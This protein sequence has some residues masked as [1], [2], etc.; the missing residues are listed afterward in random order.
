MS[1]PPETRNA[2]VEWTLILG[3]GL[4]LAGLLRFSLR[5]FESGD[6]RNFIG[7]WYDFIVE[8]GGFAALKHKFSN[9]APPYWY[10]LTLAS[11]LF[12]GL[13]RVVAV[14]LIPVSFDFVCAAFVYRLARLQYPHGLAPLGAFFA[15]LF[16][17][18]VVLNGSFWG[19][20]DVVYTTG[21]VACV[22]FLAA[23][24][25]GAAFIAF[26]LAFAFKLQ[27]LFLAPLLVILLLKRHVSW[28]SFLLIPAMY[29]VCLLP[30]WL[31]GHPLD[32]L[33]T[34]YL[35]QADFYRNLTKNAPNL[36]QWFPDKLYDTLYPAGIVWAAGVVGL[37]ILG[38]YRSRAP[39][40]PGRV[41]QLATVSVV[42]L[43]FVL[44]KMHERYF[45]SADVL[46]IV[47]A[48]YFPQYFYVPALVGLMSFLS[49]TPFLFQTEIVP[50][51]WLA[52]LPL[53][54]LVILFPHWLGPLRA[55]SDLPGAV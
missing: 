51:P 15:V 12:S 3:V 53:L 46:S 5:E 39:L 2:R 6:F 38:A 48:F 8:H 43:P 29:G 36:Y 7:P 54:T 37:F 32:D 31:A 9:Y 16:A 19:Q 27:A 33:L 4:M 26:G 24:R 18:T 22:Y 13:P 14:K 50:L 35:Q 47:F 34:I 44:P 40:T 49:Y 17:P 42:L 41:V 21:V 11:Y 1:H 23:R 55:A 10:I 20:V 25:E 30:A 52:F 45:F 28:K